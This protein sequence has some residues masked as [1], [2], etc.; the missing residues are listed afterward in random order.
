MDI[1]IY[2]LRDP[3]DGKIKYVGQTWNLKQRMSGHLSGPASRREAQWIEELRVEGLSPLPLVLEVVTEENATAAEDRWINLSR[4][5]GQILN[6][7]RA[8]AAPP[9][10]GNHVVH[11]IRMSGEAFRKLV[12]LQDLVVR[13][14]W[15]ALGI[16]SQRQPTLA[17]ILEVAIELFA[18]RETN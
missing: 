5:N 10:R 14:G 9:R 8:H 1:T 16:E 6:V 7:H 12:K 18:K 17:A 11:A 4:E 13:C 3:R 2:G 15:Q